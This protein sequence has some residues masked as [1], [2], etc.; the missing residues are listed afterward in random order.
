MNTSL[1][2]A[3]QGTM[4][5]YQER[6]EGALKKL[7]IDFNPCKMR[8]VIKFNDGFL[9]ATITAIR[10]FRNGDNLEISL[11]SGDEVDIYYS[12]APSFNRRVILNR[13]HVEHEI[14]W[15][16]F[17]DLQQTESLVH[18]LKEAP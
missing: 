16:Y 2:L 11:S 1:V 5:Y 4:K 8:V 3:D 17:P 14:E 7:G 13:H 18:Q 10:L 6:R 15:I 9:E 12:R